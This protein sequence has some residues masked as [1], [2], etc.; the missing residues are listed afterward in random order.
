MSFRNRP[1]PAFFGLSVALF[2]GATLGSD[3][4]ARTT[5]GGEGFMHAIG[6][7]IYYAAAQPI[8]TLFLLVPFLLLGWMSAS[9]AARK[10][11]DPGLGVF[12]LGVLLLGFTYF[13]A[14][15]DTYTYMKQRMWTAATLSIG[16]LPLKSIL[17]LL[18]CFVFR[19]LVARKR[20]EGK[21]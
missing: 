14:Y 3:V 6:Q 4:V 19:W 1:Y 16:F 7:H 5:V 13:S 18:A 20:N 15:Q 10:G 8:G 12:L 9:L 21:A 11:F 2:L 17:P